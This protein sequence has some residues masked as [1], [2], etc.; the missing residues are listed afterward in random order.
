MVDSRSSLILDL[1]GG[2]GVLAEYGRELAL[3]VFCETVGVEPLSI[4]MIGPDMEDFD[5]ILAIY[6]AGF[7]G[8]SGRFW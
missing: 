6:R 8:P 7:L 4:Y 3:P 2:D 5:H 1:G